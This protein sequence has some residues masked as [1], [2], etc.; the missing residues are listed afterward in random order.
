LE[1]PRLVD[2]LPL[3]STRTDAASAAGQPVPRWQE[4]ELME[5]VPSSKKR[6]RNKKYFFM[7]NRI[8]DDKMQALERAMRRK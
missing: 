1:L 6:L 2:S 3:R 8:L 4:D 5:M 7:V